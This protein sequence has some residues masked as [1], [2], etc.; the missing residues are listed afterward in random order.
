[1]NKGRRYIQSAQS[2]TDLAFHEAEGTLAWVDDLKTMHIF[3]NG[4]WAVFVATDSAEILNVM[5]YD[6]NKAQD[7]LAIPDTYTELNNYTSPS[8]PAGIYEVGMSFTWDFTIV[9]R[10]AYF[11]WTTDGGGNWNEFISEPKDVQD[12]QGVYYQYPVDHPGGPMSIT[13]QMRKEDGLGVLNVTFSDV[14]FRRVA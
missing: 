2:L 1:M 6:Y 9:N 10:S 4:W 5:T 8:R 7:I 13:T 3:Q 14:W 12:K 11:R